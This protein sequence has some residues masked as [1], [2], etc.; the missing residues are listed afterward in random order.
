MF[1][2][3]GGRLQISIDCKLPESTRLGHGPCFEEVIQ[4]RRDGLFRRSIC[5]VKELGTSV[6][7]GLPSGEGMRIIPY[8]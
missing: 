2:D 8:K 6:E 4:N 7:R 1:A 3:G 5:P